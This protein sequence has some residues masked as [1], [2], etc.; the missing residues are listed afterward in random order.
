M[1][2]QSALSI[3]PRTGVA[4]TE[5]IKNSCIDAPGNIE[6]CRERYGTEC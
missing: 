2:Q 4:G 6:Y 5:G 3:Q 1:N